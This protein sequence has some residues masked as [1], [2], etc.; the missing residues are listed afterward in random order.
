VT[1]PYCGF[2]GADDYYARAAA[3]NVVDRIAVPGLII[4]A[5]NDPFIR[6]R[7]ETLRKIAANPSLTY[8]ETA[9]GGHCAF[10][11]EPDGNGYDGRWA[12]R[13]VVEFVKYVG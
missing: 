3:A 5:A 1:A 6:V 8:V 2:A 9:D 4:H 10:V 13:E 11:G 7:P 12:E